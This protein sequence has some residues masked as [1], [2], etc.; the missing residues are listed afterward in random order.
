[1]R[2][3]NPSDL[4]GCGGDINQSN[5]FRYAEGV[6]GGGM[7]R[8]VRG[9]GMRRG[10]TEEVCEGGMWRG[11]AE[12]YVEGTR[13]GYAEG[14]RRV[15]GGGMWRG[16]MEGVRG[17]GTQRGYTEGYVEGGTWRGYAEGTRYIVGAKKVN[18]HSLLSK[19]GWWGL[20]PLVQKDHTQC[21]EVCSTQ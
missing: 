12:G 7:Q 16:Y 11:Y 15:C 4:I 8:G 18:S 20:L 6:R 2:F 13:R 9:G 5:S 10:Y 19:Y 14:M 21:S 3:F 1:M 17:E